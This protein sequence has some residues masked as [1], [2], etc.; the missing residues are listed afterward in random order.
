M[1]GG[2]LWSAVEFGAAYAAYRL[3][4]L[5]SVDARIRVGGWLGRRIVP[6]LPLT[7]RRARRNL[8]RIHPAMPPA[9]IH[10]ITV[11][12]ADNFGRLLAEYSC[13]SQIVAI[14]GRTTLDG[15]GLAPLRAAQAAGRGALLVSAHFGN[16]EAI[17][18]ALLRAG[19]PC[20]MLYRAFNN[21][22]FDAVVRREM[23]AAGGPV[24]VKGRTGMRALLAHLARGGV[25]MI[26]VDQKQTRAPLLPFLGLP[27]ETTLTAADLTTRLAIPLIP[28]VGRRDPDGLRFAVT[29]EAPVPDGAPEARMTEVNARIS[30]WITQMPGQWFW[31]HNRWRG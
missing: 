3:L 28:A 27:A 15:D 25:A 14:P 19:I 13:L 21:P 5:L 2:R 4:R 8:A 18:I 30:A 20:A 24:F 16:W 22:A 29:L 6:N 7:R 1:R 23:A 11:G 17:R 26:L 31:L 10:A 9:Q 12:M